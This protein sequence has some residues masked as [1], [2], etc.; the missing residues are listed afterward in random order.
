MYDVI[1]DLE[2]KSAGQ[3]QTHQADWCVDGPEWRSSNSFRIFSAK[4][5]LLQN[6]ESHQRSTRSVEAPLD[7]DVECSRRLDGDIGCIARE[8]S[9]GLKPS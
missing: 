9:L 6:I 2:P 7:T 5:L 3:I 4:L 8:L 1:A